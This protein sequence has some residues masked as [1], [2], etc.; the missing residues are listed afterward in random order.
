MLRNPAF[1]GL[2]SRDPANR[3]L[4]Q[5]TFRGRFAQSNFGRTGDRDRQHRHFGRV[6]GFGGPIFWPYAYDDFV[7]YT[8][9]PYAYDTFWP[10]AYDDVFEGI[11]GGYAPWDSGYASGPASVGY[12]S[13]PTGRTN[14]SANAGSSRTGRSS[15]V[16]ALTGDATQ[17]CNGPTTALADFPIRQIAQQV[18]PNREQQVLLDDLRVANSKAL[19]ELRTACPA[20]L[21]STP[22][23]RLAAMRGRVEAMLQTVRYIAP[24]LEK[25]YQ[26]LN[27]EQKERFNALDA[28]AAAAV[29]QQ[30]D[31]AQLCGRRAQA[32]TFPMAR[33]ERALRPSGQQEIALKALGDASA[34]TGEMLKTNCV[35]DQPL[36]PTSRLA[37]MENRLE[38]MLRVLDTV[39]PALANFYGSLSDEQK[40]K[41]NRLDG[42]S[43]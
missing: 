33:I 38:T 27:D 24:A 32:T 41:F 17:I 4:A 10:S 7:D 18:Q 42:R 21:P 35:S 22:T 1:A 14:G 19:D 39:Q 20:D 43:T 12:S 29:N 36:T 23:G 25:F 31:L 11:Y 40:A 37:I 28:E 15:R 26:S 9:S 30:P 5:S 16:A 6:I 3:A 2:P 8:F 13:E 34:Q